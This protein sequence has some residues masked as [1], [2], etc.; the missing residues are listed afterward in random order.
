MK[1][2]PFSAT[3]DEIRNFFCDCGSIT[4]IKQKLDDNNRW[5]GALFIKFETKTGFDSAITYNGTIWS[6]SGADGKR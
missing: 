2:L 5:T 6:G 4:S 1:G 3:I